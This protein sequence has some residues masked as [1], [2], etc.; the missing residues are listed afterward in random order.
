ME[1]FSWRGDAWILFVRFREMSSI[2]IYEGENRGEIRRK[3]LYGYIS[4]LMNFLVGYL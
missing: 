1:N 4:R 3:K 2:F